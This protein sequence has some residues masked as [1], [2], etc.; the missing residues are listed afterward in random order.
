MRVL[1]LILL[2]LLAD[3]SWA[4]KQVAPLR[5]ALSAVF[6]GERQDVVVRWRNYLE[7]QLQR[8]VIFV[9]RRS[10]LELT[11]LLQQGELDAAWIC[12]A[13]YVKHKSVQKLLAIGVWH[14][15][16]LYQSYLIVPATDTSTRSIA[17]LRDKVFAYSDPESNSGYYVAQGELLDLGVDPKN[18][19]AKTM[20]TYAHR[21]NVEAVAA[22]LVQGSRVDGYIYEMLNTLYPELITKTRVVQKSNKYGFPP[23][24]ARK[25]LS[26]VE[27]SQLSN[28]L[29]NMQNDPE[30]KSLLAALGL[31]RFVAGDE[32]LFD[33]VE[34]LIQRV[35]KEAG[36]ALAP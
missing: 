5:L 34:K 12:S 4:V 27:F 24:V 8:P 23:I 1:C 31:D 6:L 13:P 9:Q 20:F 17:D 14:S 3:N 22:G 7:S 32:H 16:P 33:D 28:V 10:Y 19:F 25:D 26:Q 30:G 35:D 36:G 18:F 21:K 15:E 29:L 11:D 2:L